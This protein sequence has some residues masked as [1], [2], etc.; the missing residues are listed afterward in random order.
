MKFLLALVIAAWATLAAAGAPA[1]P[2]CTPHLGLCEPGY[3]IVPGSDHYVWGLTY[4][5]TLRTASGALAAPAGTRTDE[6]KHVYYM[7]EDS[8]GERRWASQTCSN[9]GNDCND[10]AF[11]WHNLKS[12]LLS[13]IDAKWQLEKADW[14]LWFTY[15]CDAETVA[16]DDWKGRVCIEHNNGL[17]QERAKW[18]AALPPAAKWTVKAIA[19]GKRPIQVLSDT[20]GLTPAK[21]N[22]VA[23]YIPVGSPCYPAVRMFKN[24]AGNTYASIDP[25]RPNYVALCSRG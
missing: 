12:R 24:V 17:L 20:N 5:G 23:L 7:V 8:I 2:K 9:T 21:D 4:D 11:A 13:T 19:S 16:V 22:G 14:A 10:L 1:M 6:G 15:T 25:A 3:S 18:E